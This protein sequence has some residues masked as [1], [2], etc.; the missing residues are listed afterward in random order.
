MT[1][2]NRG[3]PRGLPSVACA[4]QAADPEP[5]PTPS[6][7][8]DRGG[9]YPTRRVTF[10]GTARCGPLRT[11]MLVTQ[12]ESDTGHG[13][14]MG[15]QACREFEFR[16]GF[17]GPDLQRILSSRG[18][19]VKGSLPSWQPRETRLSA[20][21]RFQCGATLPSPKVSSPC[22]LAAHDRVLGRERAMHLAVLGF[23]W[24][25]KKDSNLQSSDQKSDE[26]SRRMHL[27]DEQFERFVQNLCSTT[28]VLSGYLRR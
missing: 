19:R 9:S 18:G 20:D 1:S 11:A 16:R 10:S 7:R 27:L 21:E 23:L 4:V 15:H 12:T 6:A 22:R 17:H 28:A 13:P 25:G 5:W 24:L 26:L 3:G 2:P 14:S 8:R